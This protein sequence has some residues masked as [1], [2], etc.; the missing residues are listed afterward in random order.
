MRAWTPQELLPIM[1]PSVQRE[2]VA[3]SGAKVRLWTLGGIAE[4]VQ[5]DAGLDRSK[6]V[7]GGVER[8]RWRC[9]KPGEVEHDGNIAGLAGK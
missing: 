2:W 7:A 8:A 6:L 5:D 9:M 3:G 4:T 1:P